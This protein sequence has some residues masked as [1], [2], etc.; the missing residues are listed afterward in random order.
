[1]RIIGAEHFKVKIIQTCNALDT[2]E[3]E[4]KYIK[5]YDSYHNGYNST[6]GGDNGKSIFMDLNIDSFIDDYKSGMIVIDM[7][8][9]YKC[10]A[11]TI[12][13]IRNALGIESNRDTSHNNNNN[14]NKII[15]I[16]DGSNKRTQRHNILVLLCRTIL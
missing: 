11:M 6:P 5:Q 14:N 8:K 16:S 10:S 4:I 15:P 13:K 2:N 1:M 7:A 3:L 9:K 12:S